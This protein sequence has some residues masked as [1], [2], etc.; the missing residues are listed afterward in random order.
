MC[1]CSVTLDLISS[2]I[3]LRVFV[4]IIILVIFIRNIIFP[5][6]WYIEISTQRLTVGQLCS[7]WQHH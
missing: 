1:V 4:I 3:V 5:G 6:I 7:S 2:S